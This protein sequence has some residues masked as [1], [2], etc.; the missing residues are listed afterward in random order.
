MQNPT[1]KP[2]FGEHAG[3]EASRADH[4]DSL[5]PVVYVVDD[6]QSIR[7]SLRELITTMG[8]RVVTHST[9]EQFLQSYDPANHSCLVIDMRMP[10]MTG[11]EVQE[12]LIRRGSRLPVIIVTGH[13]DFASCVRAVKQGAVEFLEKPYPPHVLRNCI[14]K[15]LKLDRQ[16]RDEGEREVEI[17]KIDRRRNR[18]AAGYRV[19]QSQS[20]Y[21]GRDGCQCSDGPV[22][23]V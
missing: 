4:H 21:R 23:A 2:D 22:P 16:Q 7:D 17:A 1:D 11:I 8:F 14:E 3:N 6:D 20:P 5:T 12:A 13:G 9:G 19:G 10:G 18:R 15:A